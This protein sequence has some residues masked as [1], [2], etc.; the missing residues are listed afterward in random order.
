LR[1]RRRR[2]APP[3]SRAPPRLDLRP[4][5]A[6]SEHGGAAIRLDVRGDVH[7]LPGET[8][9]M[10]SSSSSGSRALAEHA[11]DGRD[12][13]AQAGPAGPGSGPVRAGFGGQPRLG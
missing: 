11:L 13:P 12:H 3:E 8:L 1:F 7:D 9:E 10:C 4:D 6:R 2:A 5:L